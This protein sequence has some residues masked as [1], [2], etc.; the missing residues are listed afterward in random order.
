M[1]PEGDFFFNLGSAYPQ[2]K[3]QLT[4]KTDKGVFVG[5]G[6]YNSNTVISAQ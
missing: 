6:A 5:V 3:M 1:H 4:V 2:V